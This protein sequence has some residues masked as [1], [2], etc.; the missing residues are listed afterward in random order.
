LFESEPEL[1]LKL[2]EHEEGKEDEDQS[3]LIIRR[4]G[5]PKV[6][7]KTKVSLST[8]FVAL[9]KFLEALSFAISECKIKNFTQLGVVR[10]YSIFELHSKF[11]HNSANSERKKRFPQ[12]N[13]GAQR[14]L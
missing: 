14:N 8:K 4:S 11:Q 5:L 10:I 9:S 13:D 7:T 12:L 3:N 6:C 2:P 1:D